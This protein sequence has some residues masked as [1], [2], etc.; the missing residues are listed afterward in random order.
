MDKT[1]ANTIW[2]TQ[3]A[4][5]KLQAELDHLVNVGRDEVTQRIAQARDEGDLR[6]N[7]GYHAAREEQGQMEARIRL[8]Q[9][10]LRRAEVGEAPS[11]PDEVAAGTRVTIAFDGDTSDTDTFLLGSREVLGLDEAAEDINVYSPQSPLGSAILGK[12]K[13]DDVTYTAP[14]GRPISVTIVDVQPFTS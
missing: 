6:E 8:L 4:Y 3:E 2:L 13:G 9:D 12:R 1:D 14:N 7:G 11:D 10:M 5:D